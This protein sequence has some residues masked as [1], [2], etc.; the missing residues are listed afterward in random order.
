M[1]AQSAA[2]VSARGSARVAARVTAFG[3]AD[4]VSL[5]DEEVR[6]PR[7]TEVVVRVTHASMGSTDVLARRG[8]YVLQPVPGFVT[9]YDFVGVLETESAVSAVLGLRAGARVAGVLPRMGAHATR[10]VL[11]ATLLSPVPDTLDSAVAATAPLDLITA[12]H[13]LRLAAVEAGGSVLVQGVTGPVG[14]FAAQLAARDGLRV[15]GSASLR[16]RGDAEALGVTFVDYTDPLWAARVKNAS[17]G[18]V[19][20]V[21]DHTGS[22]AVLDALAPRGTVVRT[23]FVGRREHERGD[24]VRGSLTAA[25]RRWG[26]QRE[27]VCSVPLLVAT[28]RNDY[29]RTLTALLWMLAA[30]ELTA[31]TVDAVPFERIREAHRA[32]D[33]AERGRKV[34]VTMPE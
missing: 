9:G 29:R 14:S 33:R 8:G 30:G 27:R 25:S 28:R 24:S 23:A 31:P 32:A 1:A 17:G 22:P 18:G 26:E 12:S 5:A 16:S 20:A 19:D 2:T 15:F 21:V 4:V 10:L 3:D 34:V 11:P 13:A 7:G 6:G